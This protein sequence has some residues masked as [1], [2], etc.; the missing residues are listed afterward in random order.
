MPFF[1]PLTG[2]HVRMGGWFSIHICLSVT[3]SWY[4]VTLGSLLRQ[5]FLSGDFFWWRCPGCKSSIA[6]GGEDERG[7]ESRMG[8]GQHTYAHKKQTKKKNPAHVDTVHSSLNRLKK[9]FN[10]KV[11]KYS[12]KSLNWQVEIMLCTEIVTVHWT[13]QVLICISWQYSLWRNIFYL[14]CNTTCV[15][16]LLFLF[17]H[18]PLFF[19]II[20]FS[21]KSCQ[22]T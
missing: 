4:T 6:G 10:F 14:K 16:L 7:E 8:E 1:F 13:H 2:Q 9:T 12:L 3:H 20:T 5:C 17:N 11:Q 22:R 18:F 15:S 21:F 19:S